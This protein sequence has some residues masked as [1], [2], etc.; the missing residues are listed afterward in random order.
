MD[1]VPLS[2][3]AHASCVLHVT[4]ISRVRC[5]TGQLR[6]VVE[7][8][9]KDVALMIV[10][11]F[12]NNGEKEHPFH[13]GVTLWVADPV[14]R[15][16]RNGRCVIRVDLKKTVIEGHKLYSHMSVDVTQF[17]FEKQAS[18]C[19]YCC[20]EL[21]DLPDSTMVVCCELARYCSV[22]HKDLDALLGPDR[23]T[24]N[25]CD[26][27]IQCWRYHSSV[28]DNFDCCEECFTEALEEEHKFVRFV[29]QNH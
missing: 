20:E 13:R 27:M 8:K 25:V 17:G 23:F 3:E 18:L 28:E 4:I 15:V 22:E 11:G 26:D 5:D 10:H 19:N 12:H 29:G 16:A 1:F 9:H 21:P 6:M 7:D 2:N 14:Q 24:C